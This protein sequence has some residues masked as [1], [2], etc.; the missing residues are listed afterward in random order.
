[1]KNLFQINC[2]LLLGVFFGHAVGTDL[3]QS[4]CSHAHLV[5]HADADCE[6][7]GE[8]GLI[9]KCK[10]GV[11][12]DGYLNGTGCGEKTCRDNNECHINAFCNVEKRC[13]CQQ[14]YAGTPYIKCDDINECEIPGMCHRNAICTNLNGTFDCRCDTE[15]FYYGNGTHCDRQCTVDT[16]CDITTEMCDVQANKCV[17]KSGFKLEDGECQNIDECEEGSDDCDENAQCTDTLGSY[18]CTCNNGFDGNGKTCTRLP[19]NCDDLLKENPKARSGDHTIDPDGTE[20]LGSVIV[21]CEMKDK[22]GTT[23]MKITNG[24]KR[25]RSGTLTFW[26]RQSVEEIKAVINSSKHCYQDVSYKCWNGAQ[27]MNGH[28]YWIDG[29]EINQ[30]NWGGA[31]ENNTCICGQYDMC[32]TEGDNCFCN[33]SSSTKID[34]GTITNKS[35][36][37]IRGVYSDTVAT[38]LVT[39]GHVICAPN[40]PDLPTDCHDAKY[41]YRIRK[42]GVVQI[43]VDGSEGELEPIWVKCD[44]ETYKHAGVTIIDHTGPPES[45]GTSEY[46]YTVSDE[47]VQKLVENS[48]FCSQS[49]GYRCKNSRLLRHNGEWMG[50]FTDLSGIPKGHWPGGMGESNQCACGN[51]HRCENPTDGCNCDI[52]DG[53]WRHD[54]GVETDKEHLPIKSV[55]LNENDGDESEGKVTIGPLQCS[56]REFGILPTCQHYVEET[57]AT[58]S[59]PYLID[60]DGPVNPKNPKDNQPPFLAYC[61]IEGTPMYGITIIGHENEGEFTISGSQTFTYYFANAIQLKELT[62]RST[63]CIQTVKFRCMNAPIHISGTSVLTFT[64]QDGNE[65]SYLHGDGT[66][67]SACSCFFDDPNTCAEELKCNCDVGDGVERND[68]WVFMDKDKLPVKD[69]AYQ[70]IGSSVADISVGALECRVLYPNCADRVW[71]KHVY[72]LEYEYYVPNL[73]AVVDPDGLGP[74]QPFTVTCEGTRT[75]VPVDIDTTPISGKPGEGVTQCYTVEYSSKDGVGVVTSEQIQALVAKSKHCAQN[76]KKECRNAPV[77]GMSMFSTCAGIEQIGW[78]GSNGEDKCACGV[79]DSCAGSSGTNCSCDVVDGVKREDEGWIVQKDRLGVCQI[80]ISLDSTESL[81]EELSERKRW[82]KPSISNLFCDKDRI[83]TGKSCQDWRRQG[84]TEPSTQMVYIHDGTPSETFPVFCNFKISPPIGFSETKP[85]DPEPPVPSNGT[86]TIV[87]YYV[88]T[89]ELIIRYI[90]Q[91]GYCSQNVFLQCNNSSLNMTGYASTETGDFVIKWIVNEIGTTPDCVEGDCPCSLGG[92]QADLG[93]IFGQEQF[94]VTVINLGPAGPDED[95]TLS[96]GSIQCFN[97]YR[98]CED[99]RVHDAD[100]NPFGNHRYVIDPDGMAG[101]DAFEVTC[102]FKTVKKMGITKVD[103]VKPAD[104]TVRNQTEPYQQVVDVEYEGATPEQIKALAHISGFCLQGIQYRC[105]NSPITDASSYSTYGNGVSPNFGAADYSDATA[106]ACDVLHTCPEGKK[107]HCDAAGNVRIE[108]GYE[109]D[110]PFE[111]LRFGGQG[112]NSYAMYDI[113]GIGCA[114]RPF[115]LPKDCQDVYERGNDLSSEYLIWPD[116]NVAPYLVYCNMDILPGKGVVVIKTDIDKGVSVTYDEKIDVTYRGIKYLEQLK[117]LVE[118]SSYCYQPVKYICKNTK[119]I[120]GDHFWWK[121]GQNGDELKYFA[122]G[123][124]YAQ[125]CECGKINKCGGSEDKLTLINENRRCNCDA[126][127]N[128]TRADA[129]IFQIKDHLAVWEMM[130]KHPGTPNPSGEL[131]LGPLYCSQEELDLDECKMG[132]HDCHKHAECIKLEDTYDCMCKE[133]WQAIGRPEKWANGRNCYDD[134]ECAEGVNK[135]PPYAD[136]TN[137]EG[138][139]NCTCQEGFRPKPNAKKKCVDI[140]E[141]VEGTHNCDENAKCYNKPG[142]YVCRCNRNY[143]GDGFSCRALAKC[144]VFGDPHIHTYDQNLYHYQGQCDYTVSRDNCND[145]NIAP[146]FEV[147]ANFYKK[148]EDFEDASWVKNVTATIGNNKFEFHPDKVLV[149]GLQENSGLN[150]EDFKLYAIGENRFELVTNIGIE[151]KYD[152]DGVLQVFV[153]GD[154]ANTTCGLCGDYNGNPDD[155]LVVGPECN[156]TKGTVTDNVALF[157]QSWTDPSNQVCA[158]NCSATNP[159]DPC[160]DEKKA[161][162]KQQCQRIYGR[163]RHFQECLNNIDPEMKDKYHVS[164]VYDVCRAEGDVEEALCAHAKYLLAECSSL[165]SVEVKSFRTED[166]CAIDC[167]LT[168]DYKECVRQPPLT[169]TNYLQQTTQATTEDTECR[170][171]CFCKPGYYLSGDECV[172]PGDCGC[173]KDDKYY[174][175]GEEITS[176]GCQEKIT[177]EGNNSFTDV[178]TI[179]CHQNATCTV[180]NGIFGCHCNDPLYG[181]G[182]ISCVP[183]P[184]EPESP[185]GVNETCIRNLQTE[186]NYE[187]VCK[188]GFIGDCGNCKEIDECNTIGLD[189]CPP[190]SKCVNEIGSHRCECNRGFVKSGKIC[191][192]IDECALARLRNITLCGENSKCVDKKGRHECRCCSGYKEK[193]GTCVKSSS[194]EDVNDVKCCICIGGK[195]NEDKKICGTDHENYDNYKDMVVRTCEEGRS[196]V[197]VDY[198]GKCKQ[199]CPTGTE[200]C[201]KYQECNDEEGTQPPTC[202]CKECDPEDIESDKV[203]ATNG[204]IY[205]NKCIFKKIQCQFDA[206]AEL[207]V[208][209]QVCEDKN[210]DLHTGPWTPW[211]EC[212]VTCG[213]GTM[214]RSREGY[215]TQEFQ[216]KY[217]LVAH[218]DCYEDPCPGSPCENHTATCKAKSAECIVNDKGEAECEC[219]TCKD[220]GVEKVCGYIIHPDEEP[221]PTTYPSACQLQRKACQQKRDHEVYKYGPCDE[222]PLTCN[223]VPNVDYIFDEQY[224]SKMKVDVAKCEGGC[225]QDLDFC[226]QPSMTTKKIITMEN[227]STNPS[228]TKT[229]EVTIIKDCECEEL[230][231]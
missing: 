30:Y 12:G 21:Y 71:K 153:P 78:A 47:H 106:C 168:M 96:L 222:K 118:I 115:D 84:E 2:V 204:I 62:T 126:A 196:G 141:C 187:C 36:M 143:R 206:E 61:R 224:R 183:D 161:F 56:G 191:Q 91:S 103:V 107:C 200:I 20:N 31:T 81:P 181:D 72:R 16:H 18:T 142:S 49:A 203:C 120:R 10:S 209:V 137:T 225:G 231:P 13:E 75:I 92:N 29:N 208:N 67:Q 220:I 178:E 52:K 14:G 156:E 130:F 40:T 38:G 148:Y 53:K 122:S 19:I 89:W 90:K 35:S 74:L 201:P 216:Q 155:D 43:D 226:C 179:T 198:Y 116:E 99:I 214:T 158:A 184:C 114:P 59:H 202:E 188:M 138:S 7:I 154:F 41:N 101:V 160:T 133:G 76:L 55:T 229:Q 46:N 207:E 94:P 171:G 98:D 129:G 24:R 205:V 39:V 113:T 147:T 82:A 177:C 123:R 48:A 173:M 15:N 172:L 185:C 151:V 88:Y 139:Y 163:H 140:N 69:V 135:C 219:P 25:L 28:G 162:A 4:G 228:L 170:E 174:K 223:R 146:T 193:N 190:D 83:G 70:N 136:C 33:G 164:C 66:K 189:A 221:V 124:E 180:K 95:R 134:N 132:F 108:N 199:K 166:F 145:L 186:N 110:V 144:E 50:Y 65:M 23:I 218:A 195:C 197:Q 3:V 105:K 68:S 159:P 182:I 32:D 211:S 215:I 58:E 97:F 167:G 128:V 93:V 125:E 57:D 9:C 210:G 194:W 111:E 80:C 165:T 44:M 54:F 42:N 100:T 102:D 227:N 22:I 87:E 104:R 119:L 26:Y 175:K 51:L 45:N 150:H 117:T 73:D 34:G 63:E 17:C 11:E 152:G 213:K 77:T 230:L 131:I 149:N 121:G 109:M 85:K 176:T 217:P 64:S 112:E 169:C 37:P 192:D 27:L 8:T 86:I 6:E 212:N 1:M 60:P 5:C 127:D 157:A 79:T